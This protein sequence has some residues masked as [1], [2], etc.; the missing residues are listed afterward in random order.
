MKNFDKVL[1][2]AMILA[3]GAV[4]F[5][6][7][8][9][10]IDGSLDSSYG[11]AI[12]TQTQVTGFG[13]NTTGAVDAANGSQLDAAYGLMTSTT[14]Y[15]MFTGNLQTNYNHLDIWFDT[16]ATGQ[17]TLSNFASNAAMAPW[18]G[19][20]LS[21]GFNASYGLT[22][23][24]GQSTSSSPYTFYANMDSYSSTNGWTDAYLGSN[25]YGATGDGALSGG[26]NPGNILAAINNSN[27]GASINAADTTGMEFA[28]P[29]AALGM[30][31]AHTISII[32]AI[33]GSGDNYLSNQ[34]LSGLNTP[35]NLG[36]PGSVNLTADG[37]PMFSVSPQAVPSPA[38]VIALGLG[39]VGLAFRRR[40][41]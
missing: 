32:A 39:L 21:N 5:S 22:V 23:N 7:S 25:G 36:A 34:F 1:F 35:N 40:S 3:F 13:Q 17:N 2:S 9:P 41:R 31:S 8:T 28:I 29:L 24:G 19:A 12:A 27:V 20:T 26:T 37:N 33:N 6:Q 14:L 10:V 16:G 15:L 30:T 4:A 38:G 18:S 11:S